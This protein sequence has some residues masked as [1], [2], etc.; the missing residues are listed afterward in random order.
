MGPR[1]E[2]SKLKGRYGENKWRE[3]LEEEMIASENGMMTSN[4]VENS[5]W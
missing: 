2:S 5:V 3:D 4:E 1:D